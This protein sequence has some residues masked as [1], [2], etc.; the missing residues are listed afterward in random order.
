MLAI[1][2]HTCSDSP[3]QGIGAAE[4]TGTWDEVTPARE[5]VGYQVAPPKVSLTFDGSACT[6]EERGGSKFRQSLFI[7]VQAGP[8]RG[9]DFVTVC[10]GV[11][12]PTRALFRVDGDTLTIKE[13]AIGRP[14][15]TDLVS[16]E[17][18]VVTMEDWVPVYVYK[19]R[20]K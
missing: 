11:F 7:P 13:G 5:R 10:D 1:C 8:H 4:L 18:G 16:G 3:A 12:W 19:R 6:W 2:F 15:P 17:F 20:A 9:L 14:R